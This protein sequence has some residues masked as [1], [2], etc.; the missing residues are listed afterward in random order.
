SVGCL[1]RC[2]HNRPIGMIPEQEVRILSQFLHRLPPWRSDESLSIVL[3]GDVPQLQWI[4]AAERNLSAAVKH[5]A[6]EV[7]VLIDNDHGRAKI[8]RTNRSRQTCAPSSD[9]DDICLVVPLV[10]LRWG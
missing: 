8:P 1:G 9:N 7:E 3:A 5:F 2:V 10:R 4:P 6:A